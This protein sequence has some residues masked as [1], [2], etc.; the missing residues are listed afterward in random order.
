[1][2][3]AHKVRSFTQHLYK[4]LI[5][6]IE[7]GDF[8]VPI[9]LRGNAVCD[10]LHHWTQERPGMNSHGDLG[11]YEYVFKLFENKAKIAVI[12]YFKRVD[13]RHELIEVS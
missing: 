8:I 2:A 6:T 12:K 7:K 10:A 11:I 4:S 1:M 3:V 5:L 9:A 13:A